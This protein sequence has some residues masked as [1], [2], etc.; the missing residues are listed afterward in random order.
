MAGTRLA[1]RE[2]GD[3]RGR[4]M[5]VFVPLHGPRDE[6]AVG[7]AAGHVG[8]HDRGQLPLLVQRA[9]ALF[10]RALR[11]QLLQDALERNAVGA[12]DAESAGDLALADLPRGGGHEVQDLLAGGQGV[13]L[14]LVG[15]LRGKSRISDYVD[16]AFGTDMAREAT[17]GVTALHA[18]AKMPD[19][20]TGAHPAHSSAARHAAAE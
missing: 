2:H 11:L 6:F 1:R 7:I 10:D 14:D 17:E 20:R 9:P 12:L 16:P 15:S 8:Q 3:A 4:A 18:A 19:A 5:L 13:G